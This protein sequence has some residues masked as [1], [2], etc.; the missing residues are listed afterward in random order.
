MRRNWIHFSW[1]RNPFFEWIRLAIE[2]IMILELNGV[3]D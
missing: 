3:I 2:L 1:R